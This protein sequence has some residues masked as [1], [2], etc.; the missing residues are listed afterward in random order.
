MDYQNLSTRKRIEYLEM[1]R[2]SR[3]ALIPS[4]FSVID[5]ITYLFYKDFI[6][7]DKA[8]PDIIISKGHAASVLYPFIA[9]KENL[10]IDFASDGSSFGIYSNLEIPYIHMPSG[11]LG[12]GLGVAIGLILAQPKIYSSRKLFVVL[13]DGECFEGSI[14]EA[15]MYI[16]NSNIT[17]II[18]IIDYNDRTILGDIS[19]TYPNFNLAKK[20]SGFG[21]KVFDFSGHDFEQISDNVSNSLKVKTPSC[22]LARTIKG[23]GISF[24]E[25]SYLWHNKM[26]NQDLFNKALEKLKLNL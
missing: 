22:L 2:L 24:M 16:S 14:W 7:V 17:S 9:E 15:L 11:S 3:E 13:G 25:E 21:F 20:L 23:K 8:I 4:S 26:P 19:R 5:L 10:K 12:H 1:V 18:P 6:L